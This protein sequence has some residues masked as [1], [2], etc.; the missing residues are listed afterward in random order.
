MGFEQ[1]FAYLNNYYTQ[2][3]LECLMAIL[4]PILKGL[5]S[6]IG[7]MMDEPLSDKHYA[8]AFKRYQVLKNLLYTE[9]NL[10]LRARILSRPAIDI[11]DFSAANALAIIDVLREFELIK[12]LGLGGHA[13][14]VTLNDIQMTDERVQYHHNWFGRYEI[15][16]IHLKTSRDDIRMLPRERVNNLGIIGFTHFYLTA[17]EF[18]MSVLHRFAECDVLFLTPTTLQGDNGGIMVDGIFMYRENGEIRTWTGEHWYG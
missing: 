6:R 16:W 15:D 12:V 5:E 14:T 4:A 8:S 17:Q 13:L 7:I 2:R 11:V 10:D 18:V 1:D 3:E 9:A